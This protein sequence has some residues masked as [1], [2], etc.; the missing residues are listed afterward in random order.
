MSEDQT[1]P[2]GNES[3][4]SGAESNQS[5]VSFETYKKTVAQEKNARARAKALEE[6][7]QTLEAEKLATET[8]AKKQAEEYKKK[9]E[10]TL[11]LYRKTSATYAQKIISEQIKSEAL[12]RGCIKPDALMRL[13]DLSTIRDDVDENFNIKSEAVQALMDEAMKEHDYLF[14]KPGINI[15]HAQPQSKVAGLDLDLKKATTDDL[16]EMGRKLFK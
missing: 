13:V 8:D 2:S 6:K 14:K 16:I 15:H 9:Y 10:E 5:E 7:L 4:S 12:K 3:S 1:I 11:G